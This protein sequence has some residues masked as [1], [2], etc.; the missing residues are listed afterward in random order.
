MTLTWAPTSSDVDELATRS[1]EIIAID[2][3]DYASDGE[4]VR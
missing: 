3:S 4:G 1:R 2:R